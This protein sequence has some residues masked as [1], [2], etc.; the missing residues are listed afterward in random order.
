MSLVQ[1]VPPMHVNAV[2]GQVEKYLTAGLKRSGHE[3]NS[4]HL[5]A[6]VITGNQFLLVAVD[7]NNVIHGAAT[8]EMNIFPNETVAFITSTGGKMLANK[9]VLGQVEDWAR[10][11]GA[12][13]LRGAC[14]E[15]IARLWKAHGY[16]RKYIIVE[17]KL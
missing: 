10:Q 2:W 12:T 1:I 8:V 7:E 11:N 5:K 16:E 6:F 3:Y 4:D 13:S 14:F 17:K 15:S 9:E